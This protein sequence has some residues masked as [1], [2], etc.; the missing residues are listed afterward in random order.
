MDTIINFLETMFMHLP[1][2][3][4]VVRAKEELAAM[5]E[6]KYHELKEEGKT[7]NEAVGIVISEF[8]NLEELA[9]ELGIEEFLKSTPKEKQDGRYISFEEAKKYVAVNIKSSY[10]I[11]LGVVLCIISPVLLILLDGMAECGMGISEALASAVGLVF[12]IIMVASAVGIFIINGIMLNQFQYIQKEII[13]LDYSTETYIRNEKQKFSGIFAVYITTGVILC[14]ISIIPLIITGSFFGDDSFLQYAAT[15]VLFI[16]I[17]IAVYI[18][19]IAGTRIS[20]Y[21]VLLQEEDY[22]K[23][24]KNDT[25]TAAVASV[26]WPLITCIYLAYSFITFDWSRSWIIWPVAG[27]LFAAVASICGIINQRKS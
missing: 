23:D 8:G 12:L 16:F 19:I 25:L 9:V 26:Y 17:S 24:K 1:K 21:K 27:V 4:E 22:N 6:D 2:S 20:S 5:M 7:E 3:P 13:R 18:F 10:R 15:A 11:G 14:I